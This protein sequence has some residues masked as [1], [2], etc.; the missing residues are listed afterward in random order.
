ML[1]PT[2]LLNPLICLIIRQRI[3]LCLKSGDKDSASENKNKIFRA[4]FEQDREKKAYRPSANRLFFVSVADA[5]EFLFISALRAETHPSLYTENCITRAILRLVAVRETGAYS[6]VCEDFEAERKV[7][8]KRGQRE[9][10]HFAERSNQK[11][12]NA[13]ITL[14]YNF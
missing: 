10:A 7:A 3:P 4:V 9:L 2:A 6:D 12:L 8:F 5:A 14:L 13:K 1:L 11:E